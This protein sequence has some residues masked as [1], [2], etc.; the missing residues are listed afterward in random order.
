MALTKD[1]TYFDVYVEV[2][3]NVSMRMSEDELYQTLWKV[4]KEKKYMIEIYL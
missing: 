2:M 4:L 1:C 3:D